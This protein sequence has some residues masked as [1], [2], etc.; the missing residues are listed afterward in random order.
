MKITTHKRFDKA[1][2]K[3]TS[4]QRSAVKQ[5]IAAFESNRLDQN[6]RDHALK[7]KMK[8]LR[9]FSAGWD[10]RVIYREEGAFITIILLDAGSHNQVY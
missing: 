2:V 6:L 5:A 8:R 1:F 10:L 7:G 4:E 3:L 9:A